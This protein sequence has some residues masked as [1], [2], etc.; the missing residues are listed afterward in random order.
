MRDGGP[1]FP[2]WQEGMDLGDMAGPGMTLR[3]YFAIRIAAAIWANPREDF[4]TPRE[5]VAT[6]AY[7]QADAMLAA[8]STSEGGDDA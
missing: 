8:R 4:R 1:A 3:D 5:S 6:E 7:A 2:I